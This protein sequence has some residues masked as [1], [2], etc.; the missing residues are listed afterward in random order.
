LAFSVLD[1]RNI[2]VAKKGIIKYMA[3]VNFTVAWEP[4]F[5]DDAYSPYV[6]NDIINNNKPYVILSG[7]FIIS[8]SV[9]EDMFL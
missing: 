3:D 4:L 5:F 7:V 9:Y 2:I 1:N 6:T 8:Y